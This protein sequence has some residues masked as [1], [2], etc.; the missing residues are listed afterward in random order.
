M[1][2]VTVN[3]VRD[4][5]SVLLRAAHHY[6]MLM[7]FVSATAG[8]NFEP[9]IHV[10]IINPLHVN[11]ANW[12]SLVYNNNCRMVR[13]C[14]HD[15]EGLIACHAA[16]ST[17]TPTILYNNQYTF[18]LINNGTIKTNVGP[19]MGVA[20]LRHTPLHL[21]LQLKKSC[22]IRYKKGPS[23]FSDMGPWA[24]TL[25]FLGNTLPLASHFFH[26]QG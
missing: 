14:V 23:N 26:V 20:L 4:S 19:T 2:R 1:A 21:Q 17:R 9:N 5:F 13:N 16:A 11:K 15:A 7:T 18:K 3:F 10:H 25:L 6:S 22:P 8:N 12:E 24:H